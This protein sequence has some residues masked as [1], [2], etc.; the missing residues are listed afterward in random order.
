MVNPSFAK[1]ERLLKRSQ[2]KTIMAQGRK[3]RVDNL[4][5]LFYLPNGRDHKRL[6]VIVSKKVGNAVIRNRAKRKIREV[7]RHHKQVGPMGMDVVVVSGKA[8][9]PLP[10]SLLEKKLVN[11]FHKMK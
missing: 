5:T 10:Y 3:K 9:V 8:L 6:G 4:C 7:F 2:F 1:H 11:T